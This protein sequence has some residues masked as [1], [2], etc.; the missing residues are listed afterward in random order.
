MPNLPFAARPL[1]ILLAT[2]AIHAQDVRAPESDALANGRIPV[3]TAPDDPVHGAYGVWAAGPDYKASFAGGVEFHPVLGDRYPHNLPLRWTTESVR[4]GGREL[5]GAEP[6]QVLDD[7]RVEYRHADV[8]E[9]YDIREDGVEQTFVLARR[10]IGVSGDLVVVGRVDSELRAAARNADHAAVVFR[11]GDGRP[12]VTYGAAT[13]IDADGDRRAMTTAW[14]GERLTLRLDG[15]WLQHAAWPV[16]VDPLLSGS[17][18]SSGSTILETALARSTTNDL[19]LA[20]YTR[21]MSQGDVDVFMRYVN[22]DRSSI[23]FAGADLNASWSSRYPQVA[24]VG[25]TDT[26]VVAYQRARSSQDSVIHT[27][28]LEAGGPLNG[29]EI[30]VPRP[31]V[32]NDYNATVGGDTTVA[33][34]GHDTAW[35]AFQRDAN[36]QSTSDSRIWAVPIDTRT[37]TMATPQPVT[38]T[39]N[40]DQDYASMTK[41]GDGST[42]WILTWQEFDRTGPRGRYNIVGCRILPN[43]TGGSF[44]TPITLSDSSTSGG[45][46]TQPLVADQGGR[47]LVA[48]T[49]ESTT[50]GIGVWGERIEVRR[51]D[52][53]ATRPTLGPAR[54]VASSRAGVRFRTGLERSLAHDRDTDSH[55]VLGYHDDGSVLH[56]VRLGSS[57]GVVERDSLSGTVRA[58]CDYDA[59]NHDFQL[60]TPPVGAP[61]PLEI[62]RF[63]R[64]RGANLIPFGPAGTGTITASN[65]GPTDLPFAGSEFFALELTGGVA[66]APTVLFAAFGRLQR[67]IPIGQG[68]L[69]LAPGLMVVA[70]QGTA[71]RNGAMRVPMPLP[72]VP[73]VQGSLYWQ[74]WQLGAAPTATGGLQ[75]VID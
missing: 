60:L 52:W 66:G 55:W 4:V 62:R 24:W 75:T 13:A 56:V 57:G 3:H 59:D 45:N 54:T 38:S 20:V 17:T 37:R 48:Y 7:W 34:V 69:V 11:D 58:S 31:R 74:F 68:Q 2:A 5:L 43:G 47:Y 9:A 72:D 40:V 19:T 63:V 51:I 36:S 53:L 33:R 44:G 14:D 61:N 22:D 8:T 29:T 73:L 26:W 12:I 23:Q 42:P 10:P 28:L 1:A 6:R 25:G 50:G 21:V 18:V 70:A 46:R 64:S 39:P 15:A 41:H 27:H 49:V 71:D 67:P 65:R 30:G 32:A 35:I 16:V